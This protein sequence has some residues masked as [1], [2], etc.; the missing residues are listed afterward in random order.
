MSTLRLTADS[1]QLVSEVKKAKEA[2]KTAKTEYKAA[3]AEAELYGTKEAQLVNKIKASNQIQASRTSALQTYQKTI[4]QLQSEIDKWE[5]E[6]Q[7]LIQKLKE[8]Q[9]ANDTAKVKEYETALKNLR[10][11]IKNNQTE[12][13]SVTKGYND[14]RTEMAQTQKQTNEL[15]EELNDLSNTFE[16]VEVISD[17]TGDGMDDFGDGA[18][19]AATATFS[20]QDALSAASD[21]LQ[22][23]GELIDGITNKFESLIVDGI[24]GTINALVELGK[25]SLNTGI[26]FESAM[27]EVMATMG[28][29]KTA[30]EYSKLK[31]TAEFYGRT[32]K[33]TATEAAQALNI[34]AQSG[35][36]AEEQIATLPT[37]LNLASAGAMDLKTAATY[38]TTSVKGFGDEMANASMYGDLIAKGASLANTDALMLGAAFSGASANAKSYSQSADSLTL[39]LLR[40]AEQNI[41]G[42]DASTAL[43]RAMMDL[44][45]PTAAAKEALDLLGVSAYDDYHKAR[46]FNTVIDELNVAL[47]KYDEESQNIIKNQIFTTYGLNAFNKMVVTS[48]DKVDEWA[49][50]LENANG[51]AADMAA[52]MIDNLQGD[53]Y[54]FTSA[55]EGFGI[56]IYEAIVPG[57]RNAVQDGTKFITE[58]TDNFEKNGLGDAVNRVSAAFTNF[59]TT[60]PQLLQT[61]AP[62]IIKIFS[63]IMDI[64]VVML[65]YL[66]VLIDSVLPQ[67]LSFVENLA[68]KLPSF[69]EQ[70]M[71]T[72]INGLGWLISNFPILISTLYGLQGLSTVGAGLLDI[73]GIIAGVA[74]TAKIAGTSLSGLVSAAAP[75]IGVCAAIV[76]AITAIVAIIGT[77]YATSENF[78][79][80]CSTVLA[81]LKKEFADLGRYITDTVVRL[82]NTCGIEVANGAEA[83]NV[84][85]LAVE[86]VAT[87]IVFLVS[88]VVTTIITYIE[89]AL[90]AFASSVDILTN[91]IMSFIALWNGNWEAAATYF[92]NF[93]N[94]V[95]TSFSNMW[96]IARDYA[97][98][99]ADDFGV[100]LSEMKKTAANNDVKIKITSDLDVQSFKNDINLIA[101]WGLPGFDPSKYNALMLLTNGGKGSNAS[102]VDVSNIM[103]S[104][105]NIKAN[106]SNTNNNK[107]TSNSTTNNTTQNIIVNTTDPMDSNELFKL[108]RDQLSTAKFTAI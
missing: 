56:K 42:T 53:L 60:I 37:V 93:C 64:F 26:T 71:P 87:T 96:G 5:K 80:Y 38:A 100:F 27:S 78:R 47:Q 68:S 48:T 58:L 52:T 91:L 86:K 59:G 62:T 14:L 24:N 43:N 79:G 105:D 36:T 13:T 61:H 35:L 66:P 89:L 106:I 69:L 44:Y 97:V 92:N 40:L 55:T 49:N 34:L 11:Q 72:L 23:F 70:V 16:E 9:A 90:N 107:V 95:K 101:S 39:S 76:A 67:L 18:E 104:M 7:E 77:A 102:S 32:T 94:G 22:E 3:S 54:A 51:A 45:T 103:N 1:S 17:D 88:Q 73:G 31:E 57:I 8:A 28:L 108:S 82:L 41:K 85:L 33:Y 65:D 46:D 74:M 30:A 75:V 81:D 4:H 12:L 83:A 6:E 2:L 20:L 84:L 29:D 25:Y 15:Q 10:S 99:F 21:K 50:V 19:G 63:S 98:D